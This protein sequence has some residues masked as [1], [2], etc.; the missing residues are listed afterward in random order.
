[1]PQFTQSIRKNPPELINFT[2]RT[3][4]TCV[5][6]NNPVNKLLLVHWILFEGLTGHMHCP[7]EDDL[8]RSYTHS[9]KFSCKFN[10]TIFENLEAHEKRLSFIFHL[11]VKYLINISDAM[12]GHSIETL[13]N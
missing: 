2:L 12:F 3:S 4:V 8:Y 13:L 6:L 7:I 10:E 5:Y 11:F 9:T 1:M